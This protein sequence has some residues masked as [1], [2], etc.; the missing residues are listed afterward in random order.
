[1]SMASATAS[2]SSSA[3]KSVSWQPSQEANLNTATVG[4]PL[5]PFP[6]E[7]IFSKPGPDL[8]IRKDRSV[9]AD[10]VRPVLAMPA[11]SDAAFHVAFHRDVQVARRQAARLQ[12]PDHVAHHDLGTADHRH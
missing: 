3:S 5:C 9:F 2:S 10:E 12:F 4:L 8:V 11:E 6:L 1:M 7:L